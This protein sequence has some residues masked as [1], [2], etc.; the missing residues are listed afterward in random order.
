MKNKSNL[1]SVLDETLAKARLVYTMNPIFLLCR[2]T[3]FER[4]IKNSSLNKRHVET[5]RLPRRI[6]TLRQRYF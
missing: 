6:C 3:S 5:I 1:H 2:K 4:T